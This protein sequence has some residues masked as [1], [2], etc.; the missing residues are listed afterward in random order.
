MLKYRV[1]LALLACALSGTGFSAE[2]DQARLAGIRPAMQKFVDQ[3]EV[4]GAVTAVGNRAGIVS[5]EAVGWQDIEARRPM[6][7]DSLFRI[8]SMTKPVT[9]LGIMILAEEGKLSV[10]DPVE[11]YIPAFGKVQLAEQRDGKVVGTRAPKRPITLRDLL[12]HTSGMA[13]GVPQRPSE[14]YVTRDR[15]L[16]E[17]VPGFASDPLMFEPGS[18]WSYCNI[19]IDTLG[20][21]IE[22][23]SGDSYERFLARRVFEPLGMVDTCFYPSVKQADRVA[24]TYKR[25]KDRLV[26]S[27]RDILG[28][29]AG[30]KYP[31][32]AGGLF[33]TAADL[34]RLYRMMLQRGTLEGKRI[35]RPEIVATMTRVQTG[36]LACGFTGGMGFGFG[37]AVVREP[38]GVTAMLSKGTFGHGGA[39]GTQG[40]IDPGQD[41]FVVLLIQRIG[42]PNADASDIRRQLQTIAVAA[43]KR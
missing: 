8:A 13:G 20:R 15:T 22:V 36:D 3:G 19:G 9:A 21:V 40:W 5:L 34:S 25:E 7:P 39:F 43:A 16:A 10:E 30:A 11:K 31:I 24:V 4:A 23:V 27:K 12:T 2:F 6:R 1:T 32:P 38:A 29:T 17:A 35:L 26:A 33:S 28:P 18:K 42:L 14:L 37:W 41:L